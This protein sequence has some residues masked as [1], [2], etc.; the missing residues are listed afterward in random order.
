[1]I[2]G[3]GDSTASASGPASPALTPVPSKRR[4]SVAGLSSWSRAAARLPQKVEFS[5]GDHVS[6][7]VGGNSLAGTVR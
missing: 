2:A 4:A 1:M 7:D 6:V 5:D 3:T